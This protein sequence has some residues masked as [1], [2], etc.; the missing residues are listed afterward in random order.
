MRGVGE[1]AS[2]CIIYELT[3]LQGEDSTVVP[4]GASLS[5]A[6]GSDHEIPVIVATSDSLNDFMPTLNRHRF[7]DLRHLSRTHAV[8]DKRQGARGAE[9]RRVSTFSMGCASG[10]GT[11]FQTFSLECSGIRNQT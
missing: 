4:D 3:L 1:G 2:R 5:V 10:R 11:A 6:G 8:G 7:Q 9:T